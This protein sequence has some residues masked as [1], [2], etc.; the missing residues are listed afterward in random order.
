MVFIMPCLF[1]IACPENAVMAFWPSEYPAVP[2][3][4]DLKS[5]TTLCSMTDSSEDLFSAMDEL[6]R[7]SRALYEEHEKLVRKYKQ[8]NLLIQQRK[9]SSMRNRSNQI[10]K[11]VPPTIRPDDEPRCPRYYLACSSLSRSGSLQ[12]PAYPD[13]NY[14]T[15]KRHNNGSDHSTSRPDS[16]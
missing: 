2:A 8:I 14:C 9:K 6:R 7:R 16:Q 3:S 13:Q 5:E 1:V 10:P 11:N 15:G 12:Q 4:K